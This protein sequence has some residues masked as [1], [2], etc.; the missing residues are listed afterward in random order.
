MS[1]L[2]TVYKI[3]DR[4]KGVERQNTA[5]RHKRRRMKTIY[6]RLRRARLEAG[7]ESA[8]AAARAFGWKEGT[9]KSNENGHAP[10]GRAKAS[11]YAAAY[12]VNLEWLLD[13]KG[14]MRPTKPR[15]KVVGKVG[16]GAAVYPI[17][18]GGIDPIEPPFDVPEGAVGFLVEGDSMYPAY[19]PGTILIAR[20]IPLTEI[21][22]GMRAIV[23]LD[24]GRRLV[25]EVLVSRR[26][27]ITL[28]S[29]NGLPMADVRIVECAKVFGT[30][31]P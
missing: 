30:V 27:V 14:P 5:H 15:V 22:N 3:P 29:M 11:R 23:T 2:E 8:A 7:Y 24:D 10:F 4:R 26:G 6:E 9:T 31:E 16:A 13:G 1:M 28:H 21:S 19:R 25:K 18:D 20:P 17:D 12:R